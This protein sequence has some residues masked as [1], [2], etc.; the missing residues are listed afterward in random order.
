[1][2]DDRRDL[3]S[4]LPHETVSLRPLPSPKE[5]PRRVRPAARLLFA[6]LG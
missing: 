5:G 3:V 4:A 6:G 2:G 1:V